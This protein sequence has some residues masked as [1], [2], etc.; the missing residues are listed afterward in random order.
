M[1]P[2][3]VNVSTNIKEAGDALIKFKNN[4]STAIA[5]NNIKPKTRL[6]TPKI[7]ANFSGAVVSDVMELRAR[8]M[9]LIAENFDSP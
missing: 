7:S 3:L 4:L 1:S 8:S 6:K 5:M 2:K 9:S